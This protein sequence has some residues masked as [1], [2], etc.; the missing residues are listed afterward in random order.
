MNHVRIAVAAAVV[1]GSTGAA[2]G[3]EPCK[4]LEA[5]HGADAVW[6]CAFA[7]NDGDGTL[8]H[9]ACFTDVNTG[10]EWMLRKSGHATGQMYEMECTRAG[11]VEDYREWARATGRVVP[12]PYQPRSVTSPA[13]QVADDETSSD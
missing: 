13:Q 2:A 5:A 8:G 7:F 10:F 4:A 1:A 3:Q 11:Q 6:H 12:E 9:Y